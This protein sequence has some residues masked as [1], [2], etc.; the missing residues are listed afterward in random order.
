MFPPVRGKPPFAPVFVAARMPRLY[1][2][3]T[4]RDKKLKPLG[5]IM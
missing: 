2:A 5:S 1:L 4:A 3:A